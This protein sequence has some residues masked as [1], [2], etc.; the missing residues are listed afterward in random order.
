MDKFNERKDLIDNQYNDELGEAQ[1]RLKNDEIDSAEF[2]IDAQ[3]A[4]TVKRANWK[5]YFTQV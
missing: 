2:R 3:S 1:D 5:T 4:G